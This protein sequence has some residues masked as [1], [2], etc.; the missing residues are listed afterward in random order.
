MDDF[1]FVYG[2]TIPDLEAEIQALVTQG[3]VPVGAPF[4]TSGSWTQAMGE[5]SAP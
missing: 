3:W 4:F 1:K 2:A 5:P